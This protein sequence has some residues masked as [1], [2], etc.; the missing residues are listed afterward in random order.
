ME[1]ETAIPPPLKSDNYL[2]S[3]LKLHAAGHL[4]S[5]IPSTKLHGVNSQRT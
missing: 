2:Q 3:Y 1:M 5:S 4:E